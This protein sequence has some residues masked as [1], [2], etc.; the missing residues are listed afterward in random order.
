MAEMAEIDIRL[1]PRSGKDFLDY[2]K[3][4]AEDVNTADMIALKR[5]AEYSTDGGN[6]YQDFDNNF[7]SKLIDQQ[8]DLWTQL[9]IKIFTTNVD[10]IEDYEDYVVFKEVKVHRRKLNKSD[11][12]SAIAKIQRTQDDVKKAE[13]AIK[14]FYQ[15]EDLD[16]YPYELIS[17]FFRKISEYIGEITKSK[18]NFKTELSL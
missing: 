17:Y 15:V 12:L 18:N 6:T 5:F 16:H 11:L 4:L 9:S 1:K 2:Q 13:L 10:G 14:S 7:I 8:P 3:M